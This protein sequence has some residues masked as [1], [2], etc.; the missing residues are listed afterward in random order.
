MMEISL[1]TKARLTSELIPDLALTHGRA[2][3]VLAQLGLDA[4]VAPSTF[5]HYIKSLR[6]IGIPFAKEDRHFGA[7]RP[8]KYSYNH[9][10]EL[11]LAL[12][13]RVYGILPDP[14]IVGIVRYRHELY[15]LYRRAYLE[16]E[17]GLGSPVEVTARGRVGF[18]M[19][20]VY[21]DLKIRYARGNVIDFGA[22]R[23]VSPF[24]ALRVFAQRDTPERAQLPFDLSALAI[25]LVERAEVAPNVRK[26]PHIYDRHQ[27]IHR[28]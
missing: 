26:R 19:T 28:D 24:E 9:L 18:T 3:W 25:A 16:F 12:T 22:P 14:V 23:A 6:K 10:M 8:A 17:T 7:G 11:A 27:V 15:A 2:V 4:G 20:G 13:L 1:P 21:L 5:N